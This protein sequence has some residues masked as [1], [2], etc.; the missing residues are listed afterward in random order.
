MSDV[1]ERAKSALDGITPGP[2]VVDDHEDNDYD[3]LTVGAGTYLESPGHYTS[4]DLI[5]EV[6]TFSIELDSKDYAQIATDAKFIAAAPEL[7][8][9]LV[10]EV[11]KVR[12]VLID[13]AV[14]GYVAD[15]AGR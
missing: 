6:D 8:R 10:A 2:W 15:T 12:G 7:V 1:V 4:T 3:L 5:Y 14:A 13:G 11:E 9:E